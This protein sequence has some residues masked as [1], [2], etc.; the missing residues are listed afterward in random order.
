M[1]RNGQFLWRIIL[2]TLIFGC[3]TSTNKEIK[4]HENLLPVQIERAVTIN[5]KTENELQKKKDEQLKLVSGLFKPSI[6]V[7]KE[8]GK[9]KLSFYLQNVSG[10]EQQ[11]SY[12]SG[13]KYDII[14]YNEQNEEI[15]KWSINKAF[16]QALIVRNFIQDDK[17]NFNEEWNLKDNK[18]NLVP[19]GKYT[20]EVKIM[21]NLKSETTNQDELTARTICEII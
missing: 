5:P 18:G 12:G 17:L 3:S 11:I 4:P 7:L 16:T 6:E 21:I 1:G 20:I 14:I 10:K 8:D 9:I 2:C 15:Y 19:P 13:Q